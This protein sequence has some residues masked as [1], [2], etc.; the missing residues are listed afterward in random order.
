[1]S[2]RDWGPL[3]GF[4]SEEEERSEL[5]GTVRRWRLQA[6]KQTPGTEPASTLILTASLQSWGS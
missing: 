4:L 6:R 1:M 5:G 3:V 2:S